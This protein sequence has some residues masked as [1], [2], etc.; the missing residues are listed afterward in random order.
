MLTFKERKLL[1]SYEQMF[2][3]LKGSKNLKA[4]QKEIKKFSF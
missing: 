1:N 4:K 3:H 2:C